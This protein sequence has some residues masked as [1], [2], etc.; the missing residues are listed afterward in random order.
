MKRKWPEPSQPTERKQEGKHEQSRALPQRGEVTGPV[1]DFLSLSWR[2]ESTGAVSSSFFLV[3][4]F[5]LPGRAWPFLAELVLTGVKQKI[6][7]LHERPFLSLGAGRSCTYSARLQPPQATGSDVVER[8]RLAP[9]RGRWISSNA[10]L[11]T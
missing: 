8:H 9:A 2:G 7:G 6:Q 3:P 10:A 1:L 5:F 11:G 4:F